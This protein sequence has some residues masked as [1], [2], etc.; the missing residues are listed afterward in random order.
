MR[1]FEF[2]K[3]VGLTVKKHRP[4]KFYL[5]TRPEYL[6]GGLSGQIKINRR[7]CR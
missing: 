2:K 6:A 1:L 5:H 3:G 4:V 7:R